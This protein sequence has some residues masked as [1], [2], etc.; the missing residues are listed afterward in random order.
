MSKVVI[1]DYGAGNVQSVRFALERLGVNAVLTNRADEIRT[2]D[3]IIF[4]GVGEARSAMDQISK[5]NLHQVIPTLKQP[6]LGICLGMQI[7]CSFSEERN[8]KCLEIFEEKVRRFR[9][10]GKVPHM[11]WNTVNLKPSL[12][13]KG[14]TDNAYFYFVHSYYAPICEHTI[15][16]CDYDV[17][18]SAILEKDNFYGCQF[19]PEKSAQNGEKLIQNFLEL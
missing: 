17:S 6:F 10:S 7:I 14:I 1:I 16:S 11:G 3:K 4:P 2:A 15:G 13:L 19:H 18:F 9:V 12:L 8:T 5:N